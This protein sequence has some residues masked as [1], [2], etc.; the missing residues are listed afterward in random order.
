MDACAYTSLWGSLLLRELLLGDG[1]PTI[2]DGFIQDDPSLQRLYP[3]QLSIEMNPLK[4][5]IV[6]VR[7]RGY[8]KL[9]GK[10]DIEV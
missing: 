5:T 2:V 8:R 3:A 1:Q 10:Y 4:A 6:E 9:L 7:R